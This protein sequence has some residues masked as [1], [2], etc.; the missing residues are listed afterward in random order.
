MLSPRYDAAR[1]ERVVN[2][3]R[4]GQGSAYPT[5]R[6]QP[7]GRGSRREGWWSRQA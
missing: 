6:R 3:E 7:E 4:R 2:G 5:A 1:P